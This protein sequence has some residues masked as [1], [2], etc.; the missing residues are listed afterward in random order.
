MM[1]RLMNNELERIW[2]DAVLDYIKVLSWYLPVR[3][4]E[5][6]DKSHSGQPTPEL[7]IKA[8]GFPN[9]KRVS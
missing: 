5:N 7:R 9:R 4:E 2:K 3:T 8:R 6:H 1:A